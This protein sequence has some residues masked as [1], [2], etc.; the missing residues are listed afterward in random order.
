MILRSK[1]VSS[2]VL[3]LGLSSAVAATS[4]SDT[5]L[6]SLAGVPPA[7]MSPG[8]AYPPQLPQCHE[9]DE[10]E[11]AV[12]L[13]PGSTASGTLTHHVVANAGVFTMSGVM[14]DAIL[15]GREYPLA[16]PDAGAGRRFL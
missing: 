11:L 8:S 1:L 5:L 6:A 13:A 2:P 14:P 7:C 16:Y 4:M 3:A 12:I 10:H 15:D 9:P